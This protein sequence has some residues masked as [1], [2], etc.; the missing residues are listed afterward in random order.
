MILEDVL[1]RHLSLRGKK[2]KEDG[3]IWKKWD[4]STL[5][6]KL[7]A[8]VK[9]QFLEKSNIHT[10]SK[11]IQLARYVLYHPLLIVYFF[12]QIYFLFQFS[13][14][15]FP[16]WWGR[17]LAS[18]LRAFLPLPE[19]ITEKGPLLLNCNMKI[20]WY[21]PKM[22]LLWEK[23]IHE[24]NVCFVLATSL[25]LQSFSHHLFCQRNRL[26]TYREGTMRL[27]CKINKS[28]FLSD[29]KHLKYSLL[30]KC[31]SSPGIFYFQHIVSLKEQ[32]M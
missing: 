32:L 5:I 13:S 22:Y 12:F 8:N 4:L 6:P 9:Q 18:Y 10:Y 19:V 11:N 28:L 29:K 7:L 16:C 23:P 30:T 24:L 14:C 20:R 3:R 2:I 1:T 15:L 31:W 25:D 17:L 26:S 27:L 21:S